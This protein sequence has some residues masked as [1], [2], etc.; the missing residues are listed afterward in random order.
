[1][2]RLI[3]LIGGLALLA[4]CIG[5]LID[6]VG[7]MFSAESFAALL[8]AVFTFLVVLAFALIAVAMI[9]AGIGSSDRAG[10]RR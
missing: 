7:H 10:R 4:L 8:I 5:G 1:M 9:V 2:T 3:R 6:I